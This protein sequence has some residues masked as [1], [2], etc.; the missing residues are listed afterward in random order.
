M[1]FA[2]LFALD[3]A[4]AFWSNFERME[5]WVLLAHLAA[6]F[7]AASAVLR[8]EDKW[9]TWFLWS[10]C[11]SLVILTHAILQGAGSGTFGEGITTF[12]YQLFSEPDP[13]DPNRLIYFFPIHQGSTRID[14]S[15]GNSIYLAIYLLFNTFIAG[16]LA[17]TEKRTWL[18]W[19][20][21]ALSGISIVFIFLT[22]TRGAILGLLG[23]L[24]LAAFLT[25]WRCP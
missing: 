4:K 15:F 5:G 2:N 10:L 11:V 16:W 7:I 18:K 23:A 20:L 12:A 9:R 1:F 21:F 8:V 19:S 14:A 17:F 25:V 13:T 6:F 22:Q 24:T 3:V